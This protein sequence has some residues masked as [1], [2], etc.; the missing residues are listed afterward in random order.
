[1]LTA[2]DTSTS[3]WTVVVR[4]LLVPLLGR[5]RG[6]G[7]PAPRRSWPPRSRRD[8]RARSATSRCRCAASR[9]SPTGT[10]RRCH[11]GW[12]RASTRP[13]S[14]PRRTSQPPDEEDRVALL[15]RPRLHRR[16]RGRR[17]RPRDRRGERARL[18]HR[19]R[20]RPAAQPADRRRPGARRLRARR[21]RGA[22]RARR[23]RRRRQ[24]AHRH[25]HGLPLPDGA[26]PAAAAD[27][28][29]RDAVAVHAARREGPRRGEHDERPVRDRER[30]RR[31]ARR[32]GRRG[33]ADARPRLGAAAR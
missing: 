6:R 9:A 5:R 19:P 2:V 26:R 23:L 29:P 28:P 24:P 18:R 4:Q 25:V 11:R 16:R 7:P 32:R 20:R 21:R 27:R 22:V 3:A 30:R 17:G 13:P 15:G 1:M 10:P 14:T 33:A 31:R 12:S 8:P